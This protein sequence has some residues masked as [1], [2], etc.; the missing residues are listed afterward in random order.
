MPLSRDWDGFFK[1]KKKT[2]SSFLGD[3][4]VAFLVSITNPKVWWSRTVIRWPVGPP[5]PGVLGVC[6]ECRVCL[7]PRVFA[8]SSRDVCAGCAWGLVCLALGVRGCVDVPC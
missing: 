5:N 3:V 6:C 7:V 8:R 4:G 2:N 1:L